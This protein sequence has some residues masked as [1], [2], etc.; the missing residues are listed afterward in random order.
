MSSQLKK[1]KKEESQANVDLDE[2]VQAGKNVESEAMPKKTS[3]QAIEKRSRESEILIEETQA[4]D[5]S[6]LAAENHAVEELL[7]QA[8]DIQTF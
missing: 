2:E 5:Q 1:K 6:T 8:T 3:T 7:I 4:G